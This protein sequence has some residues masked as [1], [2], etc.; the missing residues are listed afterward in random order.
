MHTRAGTL[1]RTERIQT[2]EKQFRATV[3]VL[4]Y[5]GSRYGRKRL[6]RHE[7]QVLEAL[8]HVEVELH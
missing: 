1:Y 3:L 6:Q 4:Q 8:K 2:H 7:R 5:L